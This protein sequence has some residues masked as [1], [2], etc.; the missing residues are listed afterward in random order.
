MRFHRP[1]AT[2]RSAWRSGSSP[3]SCNSCCAPALVGFA[4]PRR[5]APILRRLR[6]GCGSDA[7]RPPPDWPVAGSTK[8]AR[9]VAHPGKGAHDTLSKSLAQRSRARNR[10]VECAGGP[11]DGAARPVPIEE[12]DRQI[13]KRSVTA[14]ADPERCRVDAVLKSQ[15]E[16]RKQ[17]RSRTP[18]VSLETALLRVKETELQPPMNG[19]DCHGVGLRAAE[20]SLPAGQRA[21]SASD[22]AGP[23]RGRFLVGEVGLRPGS[24]DCLLEEA[25]CAEA[26]TTSA[27]AA[28]PP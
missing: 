26:S 24:V 11:A 21:T 1:D 5:P 9:K 13:D 19:A 27:C 4:R 16:L 15:P 3:W 2:S 12:R 7:D 14:V 8:S 22:I 10:P 6:S 20:D 17:S 18:H 25:T 28:S 23:K